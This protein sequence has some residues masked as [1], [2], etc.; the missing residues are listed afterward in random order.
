MAALVTLTTQEVLE[1]LGY[2]SV[3]RH[4]LEIFGYGVSTRGASRFRQERPDYVPQL[5]QVIHDSLERSG[6]FPPRPS[7]EVLRDGTYLER[8]P[9]GGATLHTTVEI[10]MSQTAP[11]SKPYLKEEDAIT[12]LLLSRCDPA[13][14]PAVSQMRRPLAEGNIGV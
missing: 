6:T 7:D 9:D 8:R 12:E 3:R 14:F 4:P 10:S 13:Y 2:T 1:L 11:I 5:V